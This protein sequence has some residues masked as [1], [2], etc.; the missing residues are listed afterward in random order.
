MF[1]F[2]DKALILGPDPNMCDGRPDGWKR[3]YKNT[4]LK[5]REFCKMSGIELYYLATDEMMYTSSAI[6]KTEVKCL[7]TLGRG[8]MHFF[9]THNPEYSLYQYREYYDD[10]MECIKETMEKVPLD[11]ENKTDDARITCVIKRESRVAR[12]IIKDFNLVFNIQFNNHCQYKASTKAGDKRMVVNINAITY[13]CST[14]ISGQ[15]VSPLDI[16]D[17]P[18]AN[19]PVYEWE[20]C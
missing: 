20:V 12:S 1:G 16:I 3:N 19:M 5:I 8:D 2:T 15:V 13:L 14:E 7:N 4:I 18:N 11:A 9:A 10:Y 17:V 6:K